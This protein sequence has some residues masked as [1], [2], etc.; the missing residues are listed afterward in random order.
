MNNVM[1]HK[2]CIVDLCIITF[3][4]PAKQIFM[5]NLAASFICERYKDPLMAT[6]PCV[7]KILY[8]WV[9]KNKFTISCILR[10]VGGFLTHSQWRCRHIAGMWTTFL[11]MTLRPRL[12]HGCKV[13][14]WGT[15]KSYMQGP[16]SRHPIQRSSVPPRWILGFFSIPYLIVFYFCFCP[17]S[18]PLLVWTL[19]FSFK[20][21]LML[22]QKKSLLCCLK[23]SYL[24]F[25]KAPFINMFSNIRQLINIRHGLLNVTNQVCW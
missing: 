15:H 19:N 4:F 7:S 11:E 21:N 13:G 3:T 23:S 1:S 14:R 24:W 20:L 18:H 22:I 12:S 25:F 9:A 17:I 2:Q 6:F 16:S 10:N 8:T 5:M